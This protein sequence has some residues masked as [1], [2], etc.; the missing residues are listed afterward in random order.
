VATAPDTLTLSRRLS[1]EQALRRAGVVEAARTLAREGGYAAVTM[2]AV[3]ERAGASRAT[4][5]RWFASKDHLLGE[6]ALAWGAE[7][8]A[9]LRERPLAAE[10]KAERVAEVLLFVLGAA[11]AEPRL[12]GA[13]LAAATSPDPEA[14]RAG[15]ELGSVLGAYLG[16]AL[17]DAAPGERDELAQLLGHVFFSA[18]V[19]MTSGRLPPDAAAASI[20]AAARRLFPE[21]ALP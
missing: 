12:T 10:A 9:A 3:A 13:V 15:R 2:Q 5:Y 8:T 21:G 6:V 17:G 1:K 20:R 14:L 19:H 18:L 16:V 11:R 4:L 7:L